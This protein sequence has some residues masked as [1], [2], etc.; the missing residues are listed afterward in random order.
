MQSEA[1]RGHDLI[2]NSETEAAY[3]IQSILLGMISSQ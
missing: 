2:Q 1:R 3:Y